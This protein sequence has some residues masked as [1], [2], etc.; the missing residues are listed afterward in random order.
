MCVLSV[1]FW[2]E[3][4]LILRRTERD[5]IKNVYRSACTAPLLLSDCNETRI[6]SRDF[7]QILKYRS[8]WNSV[9]WKPRCSERTKDRQTDRQ[10][11]RQTDRT[12]LIVASH[13]FPNAS[14]KVFD[15]SIRPNVHSHWYPT[16][17]KYNPWK[18]KKCTT[19]LSNALR[20]LKPHCFLEGSQAVSVCPCGGYEA[21]A[22][23]Y[24]QGKT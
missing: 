19:L 23:W 1:Q 17:R 3:T 6:F 11:D 22:E 7:R 21:L 13:N 9:Q 14:K 8:W 10:A 18:T 16:H 24:W 2:S 20:F 12:K 4:F 15:V 5:M